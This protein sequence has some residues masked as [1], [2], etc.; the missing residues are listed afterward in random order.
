MS[1]MKDID[2]YTEK[3]LVDE[4]NRR[5]ALRSEGRCDY[6]HGLQGQLTNSEFPQ[7]RGSETCTFPDRHRGEVEAGEVISE[8]VT[9]E[10]ARWR[11]WVQENQERKVREAEADRCRA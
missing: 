7:Y 5:R 3:E 10:L 1:Y 8:A 2:E 6:C 11:K 4:L 9:Q